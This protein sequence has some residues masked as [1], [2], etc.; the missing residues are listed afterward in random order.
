LAGF[1]ISATAFDK[2]LPS[3]L[4]NRIF[5]VF[6]ECHVMNRISGD[7]LGITQ[8]SRML[9][10]DYIDDG[11]MWAGQGDRETRSTIKFAEEFARVPIVHVSIGLWDMDHKHNIRADITA[12]KITTKGFDV[13]F[14]TWGDTRIAR[15]RVDW[16]AIGALHSE[17]N[18]QLY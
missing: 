5:H 6:D 9:F 16:I 12:E 8:G 13:V 1:F 2:I 18:W 17:E 4:V 14:R 7:N 3:L 11:P 15:M 10:S